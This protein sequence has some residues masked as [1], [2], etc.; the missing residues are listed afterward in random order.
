MFL[1]KQSILQKQNNKKSAWLES[2]LFS[3]SIDIK[4]VKFGCVD[5]SYEFYKIKHLIEHFCF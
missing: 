2:T 3:D 5:I 1:Q 4:F